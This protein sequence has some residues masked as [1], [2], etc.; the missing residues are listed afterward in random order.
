MVDIALNGQ[1][2]M[3]TGIFLF[4]DSI[5]IFI[6]SAIHLCQTLSTIYEVFLMLDRK[7]DKLRLKFSRL[8]LQQLLYVHLVHCFALSFDLHLAR[9]KSKLIQN[10]ICGSWVI[11]QEKIMDVSPICS[12]FFPVYVFEWLMH[13]RLVVTS[14]TTVHHL[15]LE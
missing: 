13:F 4:F 6:F 2:V 1:D 11:V 3:C 10:E 15:D 14:E 9:Q 7:L 12:R 5:I 8:V